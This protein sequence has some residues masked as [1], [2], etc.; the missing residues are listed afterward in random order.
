MRSLLV[1]L[2]LASASFSATALVGLGAPARAELRRVFEFDGNNLKVPDPVLFETGSDHLKPESSRALEHVSAYLADKTYISLMRIEGHT[3][4]A[5]DPNQSQTLTERRALAVAHALV[6]MGVDCKR[7]LPVGFGDN[8]PVAPNDTPEDRA[9]NR[10]MTFANAAL[11]G[12]AIGGMPV[13]GGGRV[14]G[15]PCQ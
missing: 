7:L 11:R 8:K 6:A 4:N 5:G 14:A 10:R 13:D 1:A 15:D 3:D 9:Q 2:G 12:H